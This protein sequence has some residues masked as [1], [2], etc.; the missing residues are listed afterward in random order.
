[1][2]LTFR[3]RSLHDMRHD[4]ID[5]LRLVKASFEYAIYNAGRNSEIFYKSQGIIKIT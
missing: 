1:M 2:P 5:T 4:V 3:C